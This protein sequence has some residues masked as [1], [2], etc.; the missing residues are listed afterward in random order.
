M[1]YYWLQMLHI[2][3]PVVCC[4]C[5]VG[6]SFTLLGALIYFS[7]TAIFFIDNNVLTSQVNLLYLPTFL[8]ALS[9]NLSMMQRILFLSQKTLSLISCDPTHD[10]TK[11]QN[12]IIIIIYRDAFVFVLVCIH[13][14]KCS[15]ESHWYMSLHLTYFVC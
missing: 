15:M 9:R 8:S 5:F 7:I 13:V 2:F 12:L 3:T 10:R 4:M 6:S 1:Q 11:S 14:G